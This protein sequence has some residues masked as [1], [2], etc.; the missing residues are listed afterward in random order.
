MVNDMKIYMKWLSL[1]KN[2]KYKSKQVL[3]KLQLLNTVLLLMTTVKFLTWK[4]TFETTVQVL[5]TF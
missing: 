4:I 2:K 3:K 1:L 5:N